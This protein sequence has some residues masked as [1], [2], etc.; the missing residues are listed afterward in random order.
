MEDMKI[1]SRCDG[2]ALD[3]MN[4]N[5]GYVFCEKLREV[6]GRGQPSKN[7]QH[8]NQGKLNWYNKQNQTCNGSKNRLFRAHV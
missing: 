8:L 7:R 1:L 6:G 3:S 2:Y 5:I 4:W